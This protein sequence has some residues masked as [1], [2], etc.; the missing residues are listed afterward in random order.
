M[1]LLLLLLLLCSFV[2]NIRNYFLPRD[3]HM[4]IARYYRMVSV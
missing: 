4:C 2:V 1:D 3:A